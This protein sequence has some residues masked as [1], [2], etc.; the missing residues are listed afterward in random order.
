MKTSARNTF[1]GTVTGLRKAGPLAEVELTTASGLKVVS[2]ITDESATSLGVEPG[3]A[4]V[5]SVKA[6]WVI[7][8]K[9]PDLRTSGRNRF[10]AK[11][12]AIQ[13]DEISAEVLGEMEDGTTLCALVTEHSVSSLGLSVGDTVWFV[14]KAF[15]VILSEG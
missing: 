12:T 3:K 4:L 6:P 9:E 13:A 5:A 8:V 7:L 2:V 11:V 14:M 15:S 10:M 1:T